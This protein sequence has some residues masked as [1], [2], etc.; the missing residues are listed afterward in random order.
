M[1]LRDFFGQ[2]RLSQ[3]ANS[4]PPREWSRFTPRENIEINVAKVALSFPIEDVLI[5]LTFVGNQLDQ[6]QIFCNPLLI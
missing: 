5:D 6:K 4:L 3:G 1:G 2:K